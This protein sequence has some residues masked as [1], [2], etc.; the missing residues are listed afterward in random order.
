[1][2]GFYVELYTEGGVQKSRMAV[3]ADQFLVTS[4]NSRHYPLVFENGE[5][6][7]AV[8]NIGTVNAGLLQSLNGKM[9][10]DLNNGTIE[11]FS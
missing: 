5:L 1:M 7:L 2:S 11:I 8:A 6:K 4:G 10:I 9:K 3:Q